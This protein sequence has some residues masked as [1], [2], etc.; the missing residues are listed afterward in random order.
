MLC[1]AASGWFPSMKAA[2][3][4][5]AA[6]VA[7]STFKLRNDSTDGDATTGCAGGGIEPGPP[8]QLEAP[9]AVKSNIGTGD[10]RPLG[11]GGGDNEEDLVVP[12]ES[13]SVP[14]TCVGAKSRGAAVVAAVAQ[15]RTGIR[16]PCWSQHTHTHTTQFTDVAQT[17]PS[18]TLAW[19]PQQQ[20]PRL[21]L[22]AALSTVERRVLTAPTAL[23]AMQTGGTARHPLIDTEQTPLALQKLGR[24]GGVNPP[25][26]PFS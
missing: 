11:L 4:P 10:C 25:F 1:R 5:D 26:F 17:C 19:R 15:E 8:P 24:A 20:P 9:L 3:P 16:P 12:C 18:Q 21:E 2:P 22:Y 23:F 6:L 14:V 13:V 7:P